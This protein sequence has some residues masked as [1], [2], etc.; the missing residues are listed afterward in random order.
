MAALVAAVNEP[1]ASPSMSPLSRVTAI[2]VNYNSGPWLERCVRA[3]RGDDNKPPV[4]E[5]ID[6]G[7]ED[8]SLAL[9]PDLPGVRMRRSPCNLGFARAVNHAARAVKTEYLLIINPDCLL[10]P[11]ALLRLVEDLD[12]H[13]EV[14]MVS[15]RIFDMSGNE[16]RGSRRRLPTRQRVLNEILGRGRVGVD[17]TSQPPPRTPQNV[18][19]VSGACMLLRRQAFLEVGG[20]DKHYPLHFEDLDLMARLGQAGW[21]LRLLPDVAVSHVGGVSS[22]SRPMQVV[23]KKHRGLWRYL[24]RHPEPPWVW[25]NKAFWWLGIHAHALAV[26]PL[27]RW[28][29]K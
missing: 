22:R 20:F 25:W 14:G 13:P 3:L 4:V 8:E 26:M 15:G 2:V 11:S 24:N 7:S 9:L 21:L 28:Q 29:R 5:I 17:L 19:A 18:E 23:W 10:V 12:A 1:F 6:N 16:Q 27:G